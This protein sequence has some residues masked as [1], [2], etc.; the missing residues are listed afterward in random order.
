MI[1][2]PPQTAKNRK[3]GAGIPYP[4]NQGAESTILFPAGEEDPLEEEVPHPIGP[5]LREGEKK[6]LGQEAGQGVIGA[7]EGR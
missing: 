5:L 3:R 2:Y 1:V 6:S 4:W 7:G